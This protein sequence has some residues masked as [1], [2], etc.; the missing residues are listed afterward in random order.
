MRP[1][2]ILPVVFVF[3]FGVSTLFEGGNNGAIGELTGDLASK[4][5]ENSAQAES[6]PSPEITAAAAKVSAW[7]YDEPMSDD[8][9]TSDDNGGDKDFGTA[10]AQAVSTGSDF[11]P[12]KPV[13]ATAGAAV[14]PEQFHLRER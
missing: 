11:Q 10:P 1:G 7:A 13:F 4:A 6:A 2:H 5:A 3:L 14:A 12:A 8:D 9:T